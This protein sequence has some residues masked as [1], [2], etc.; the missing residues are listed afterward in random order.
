MENNN[1]IKSIVTH[2]VSLSPNNCFVLFVI[3]GGASYGKK[4]ILDL[5]LG[6][7]NQFISKSYE[8]TKYLLDGM[9]SL[10]KKIMQIFFWWIWK[11]FNPQKIKIR[12]YQDLYSAKFLRTDI[13]DKEIYLDRVMCRTISSIGYEVHCRRSYSKVKLFWKSYT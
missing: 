7:K 4:Y 8:H 11:L 1:S 12:W 9:V 13:A 2:K 6:Y 3:L 5:R 10:L